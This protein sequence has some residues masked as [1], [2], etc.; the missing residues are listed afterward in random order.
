M[1]KQKQTYFPRLAAIYILLKF[2]HK[3]INISTTQ[4]INFTED[5][6]E[7]KIMTDIWLINIPAQQ[8]SLYNP[9]HI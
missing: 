6:N 7:N 1:L 4:H 9:T 5:Y 8:L 2:G 3:Q